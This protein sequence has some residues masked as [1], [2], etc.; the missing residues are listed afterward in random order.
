MRLLTFPL[1]FPVNILYTIHMRK[2][3]HFISQA[4]LAAGFLTLLLIPAPSPRAEEEAVYRALLIA[5]DR[6]KTEANMTPIGQTNLAMMETV[7]NADTRGFIISRQYGIISSRAA[8]AYAIRTTFGDAKEGDV[9]LLYISTHGEFDARRNNPEGVLILSDGSEEDRITA[10]E[11]NA[12]LDAVPG[13][14][15]LLVDGCNSGALIGKGVSPDVSS[16]RLPKTFQSDEYK[17]LTSSGA[18]EKSWYW[19]GADQVPHGGSYFTSALAVGAGYFGTYAADMNRDGIITLFEM[20]RYLWT[21]QASSAVQVFPQEDDFPLFTYERGRDDAPAEGEL[22]G[23]VISRTLLNPQNPVVTISYTV[24]APTRVMYRVTVQKNGQW[25]WSQ[26]DTMTFYDTK[27]WDG[28]SD[29]TG[30]VTPGRRTV[31]LDLSE[32]LPEGWSYALLHVITLGDREK[33]TAPFIYAGRVLS[34]KKPGEQL[35][36]GVVSTRAWIRDYQKELEIFIAH[37][38][39]CTLSLI[40]RNEDGEMVRQL[41]VS[42]PTRPQGLMPEGS[43]LYWN[44]LDEDGNRVPE[45]S[46]TL[47]AT[48]RVGAQIE[49]ASWTLAVK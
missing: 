21:M 17:V 8:L 42:M 22:T 47:E 25:D 32:Y 39:P 37:K 5:C 35:E 28:D 24:T 29:W 6:F 20:Y 11:L 49:R 12:M 45:G 26:E 23:I 3:L 4:F 27:E 36:L 40:I 9:S 16:A 30:Q 44:G 19:L 48:A 31:Q 38:A 33:G 7:L 14:K 18:S 43:L 13:I 10:Q 2:F 15:T 46:Y 1:E 41:L 34:A